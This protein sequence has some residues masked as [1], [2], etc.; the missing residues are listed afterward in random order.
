MKKPMKLRAR[1]VRILARV[2]P[3]KLAEIRA[4]IPP[5]AEDRCIGNTGTG[6]SPH[7]QYTIAGRTWRYSSRKMTLLGAGTF[8]RNNLCN[9]D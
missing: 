3:A 1:N 4:L 2:S 7:F 5:E 9:I 6:Q 8:N